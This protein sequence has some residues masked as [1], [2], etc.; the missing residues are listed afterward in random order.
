M[1]LTKGADVYSSDGAKLGK[2]DRVILDPETKEVT[3]IVIEKG[4]LFK[5]NKVVSIDN[6]NSENKDRI[7]L[8]GPQ[9]DLD[10]YQDFEETHYVSADETDY[11][12]ADVP[13]AGVTTSYWYPPTGLAWWRVASP[14]VDMPYNPV[15]PAYVTRTKQNIPEGTVALEEGT[16]V[17]SKDGK[18]VGNIEQVIVDS[19]D[20][21]VTHFVVDEGVLFKERKL[22]P[23]LWI[24]EIDEDAVYL[25]TTAKVL[26][27]LPEY[28]VTR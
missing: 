8:L 1:R 6:V 2:L 3:H 13:T 12:A 26:E 9:R 28:Q 11:P 27:R 20:N 15:M 19:E 24:S 17:M 25:S 22:I 7:T 23:V 16:K 4:L 10:D 5:T 21:R 14:A 18:H